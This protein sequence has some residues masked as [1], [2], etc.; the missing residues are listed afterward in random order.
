M[1]RSASSSGPFALAL[2]LPAASA[3]AGRRV[4]P[5]DPRDSL[6]S[7]LSAY[8]LPLSREVLDH[9]GPDVNRL[10]I[11]LSTNP[12]VRPRVR[13]RALAALGYYPTVPTRDHLGSLLHERSLVKS[14]LGTNL[15]R[16]A[17]RSLGVAFG[18]R[19][20]DAIVGLK[21]DGDPLIRQAVA[22]ALGDTK[23]PRALPT[24]QTWLSQEQ[25]LA[26]RVAI[27]RAIDRI[28]RR[29]RR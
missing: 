12:R 8:E 6:V 22:H 9:I 14:A 7:L 13:T 27:D 4:T 26:V 17:L 1:A 24:L 5:Q 16:Q 25:E 18:D 2:A 23:S 10:L 15:R 19:A 29:S 28:S 20:V 3:S 21:E 11:Q